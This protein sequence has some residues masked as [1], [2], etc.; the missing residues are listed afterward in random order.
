M[1]QHKKARAFKALHTSESAF[2]LPNCWDAASAKVLEGAGFDAIATAS[3]AISWC[4]GVAD[5]ERLSREQMLGA[6]RLIAGCVS[7]PVSVDIEKGYGDTPAGVGETV[8]G[9]LDCGA[10]GINIEDSLADGTQRPVSDM[11][12]RIAAARDA[13][14]RAGIDLV[15]NARVD[16]YL[17]GR[18]GDKVLDDTLVRGNAWL[19]AGADCVF[20]PGVDDEGLIRQLVA[21][22]EGP[23]NIIV[24][25]AETPPFA[26]LAAL[27]VKRVSL[28][29]RLMQVAMGALA[30][31]A[32]D[33]RTSGEFGFL[34]D[35]PS[36]GELNARFR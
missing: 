12:A 33:L 10:V 14:L 24:L 26:E 16:A 31:T 32:G 5:G 20:V 23:L 2:M 36:F 13:A 1:Q 8:T 21:S 3:A 19:E 18:S 34:R 25:S 17:L 9:V 27:G 15:I 6:V 11:Q 7:T 22:I 30:Q 4:H 28:G 29:P 35:A